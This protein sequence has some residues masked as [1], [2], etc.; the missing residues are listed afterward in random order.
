MLFLT[1][2]LVIGGA[3]WWQLPREGAVL[4]IQ[5]RHAARLVYQAVINGGPQ[6]ASLACT[7]AG[8]P[9]LPSIV[10]HTSL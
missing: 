3:A 2:N 5:A 9:T 4:E 6:L 8:A 10:L 7:V 1:W